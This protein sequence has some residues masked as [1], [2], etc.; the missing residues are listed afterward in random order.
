MIKS[1]TPFIAEH[2]RSRLQEYQEARL[3]GELAPLRYEFQGRKVD[4]AVMWLET[5]VSVVD[6]DN[7]PAV[8]VTLVDVTNRK[9]AEKKLQELHRIDEAVRACFQI[10]IKG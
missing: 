9:Q 6:W 5:M 1:I 4:G 3:K 2:E 7:E 8:L 10:D